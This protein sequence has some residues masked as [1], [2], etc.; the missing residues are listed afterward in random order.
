MG[1]LTELEMGHKLLP[2]KESKLSH[3]P[4]RSTTGEASLTR[5]EERRQSFCE[6]EGLASQMTLLEGPPFL[7][8]WPGSPVAVTFLSLASR[9]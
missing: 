4:F 3:P 2:S 5:D 9:Q 1:E 8:L 7:P 6:M